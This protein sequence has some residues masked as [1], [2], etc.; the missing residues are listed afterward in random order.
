MKYMSFLILVLMYSVGAHAQTI[1][2]GGACPEPEQFGKKLEEIDRFVESTGLTLEE[3]IERTEQE[4]FLPRL[5]KLPGFEAPD[6]PDP[7]DAVDDTGNGSCISQCPPPA[8][9]ESAREECV[10]AII[11]HL[12]DIDWSRPAFAT[13]QYE[14][15]M[16]NLE[17][18]VTNVDIE[19]NMCH[20]NQIM[21]CM[22][23]P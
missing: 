22:D 9:Y 5:N 7:S 16:A 12:D 20:A 18:C 10:S 11:P 13:I 14:L 3:L 15:L 4:M 8:Y 19:E 2:F 6:D 17:L 21:S 1:C 23:W